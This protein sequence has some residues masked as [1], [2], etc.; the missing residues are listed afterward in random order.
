[1]AKQR[2]GNR[3]DRNRKIKQGE[4]KKIAGVISILGTT[5]FATAISSL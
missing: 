1:M 2:R 4:G 5:S 3:V